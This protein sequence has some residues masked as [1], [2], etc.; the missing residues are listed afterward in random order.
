M[1][2]L[3]ITVFCTLLI[4][5]LASSVRAEVT[6]SQYRTAGKDNPAIKMYIIGLGHGFGWAN[7]VLLQQ[8]KEPL[9]CEPAGEGL[10]YEDL[11]YILDREIETLE[12]AGKLKPNNPIGGI[13]LYGLTKQFAC[14]QP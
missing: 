8:K 12:K 7:A 4:M 10:A 14:Q 1:K 9:Y 2:A 5:T 3:K 11:T 6:V 13:L